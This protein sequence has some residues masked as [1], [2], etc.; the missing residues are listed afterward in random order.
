MTRTMPRA[1]WRGRRLVRAAVLWLLLAPAA[2]T[3]GPAAEIPA[4]P[5][6]TG[7]DHVAFRA[8]DPAAARRFYGTTLGLAASTDRG[9]LLVFGVSAR[10]HL[11]LV[12]GLPSHPAVDR[13][14]HVA[15]ATND[16][17]ALAVYLRARGVTVQGPQSWASCGQQGLRATDP[18]GHTVEFV[19]ERAIVGGAA[20]PGALSGRVLHAG[21]TVRDEAAATRFYGDVLGM[22]AIWRGGAD[23][24]K[25][26]WV[27]LRV[28]DGTDYLELMLIDRP[29]NPVRLGTLHHVCL[30]VADIQTAWEQVR[31][32]MGGPDPARYHPPQIGRNNRWQLNLFDPDGTRIELMELTTVRSR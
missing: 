21:I 3:A 5:L 13:L 17:V 32:R 11:V 28:P 23:P 26:D 8:S 30:A 4:R 18:D 24:D 10:Q 31:E 27:N 20:A 25:T 16:L 15:L 29:V 22:S 12:P 19:Q 9:G 14:D 1:D 6:V 7:V 2:V